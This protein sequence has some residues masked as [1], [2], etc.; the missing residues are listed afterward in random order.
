[1]LACLRFVSGK[2]SPS[3]WLEYHGDWKKLSGISLDA[4][5]SIRDRMITNGDNERVCFITDW[6]KWKFCLENA[7]RDTTY[8]GLVGRNGI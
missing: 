1:M 6:Y 2:L 8:I 3:L 4:D 7:L 5:Y